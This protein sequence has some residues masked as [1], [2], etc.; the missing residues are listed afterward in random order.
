MTDQLS[1]AQTFKRR[2]DRRWLVDIALLEGDGLLPC[3]RELLR[4]VCELA[5][6]AP[7]EGYVD[8]IGVDERS[9]TR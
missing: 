5:F 3:P 6:V 2:S 7:R 9:V 8:L 1:T 4:Y